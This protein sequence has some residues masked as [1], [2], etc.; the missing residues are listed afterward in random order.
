M[1]QASSSDEYAVINTPLPSKRRKPTTIAMSE[2]SAALDRS[3]TSDRNVVYVLPATAES[4]GQDPEKLTINRESIS[5]SKGQR[6]N[7][8]GN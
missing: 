4:L 1:I 8:K 5:T 6:D 2:V 3:K 7:S